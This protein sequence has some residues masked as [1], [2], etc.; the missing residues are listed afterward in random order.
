MLQIEVNADS[1]LT[2][3]DIDPEGSINVLFPNSYTREGFLPDGYV[4]GGETTRIP[5]SLSPGNQAGF[6][7]DYS[8]PAGLDTVQVFASTDLDTANEIRA[9]IASLG[10]VETRGSKRSDDFS[11]QLI[12]LQNELTSNVHTRAIHVVR[13][14]GQAEIQ[15]A[16]AG[17]TVNTQN[18]PDWNSVSL[19]IRISE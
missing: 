4:R 8:P 10:A 6:F 19:S 1:Y 9:W 13:D 12:E 11:Q 15:T 5:D 3:I 7:W 16:S 18:Q 14:Q 17:A 2:V